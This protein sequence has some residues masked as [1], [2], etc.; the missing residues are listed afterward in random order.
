SGSAYQNPHDE[1]DRSHE[2]NTGPQCTLQEDSEISRAIKLLCEN[3]AVGPGFREGTEGL[4]SLRDGSEFSVRSRAS[5]IN[6]LPSQRASAREA[7]KCSVRSSAICR[8]MPFTT[9]RSFN[10]AFAKPSALW[11]PP[12]I[13]A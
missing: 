7:R 11:K 3:S 9:M 4:F 12:S 1:D 8:V 2:E 10:V 5:P 6:N 13:R